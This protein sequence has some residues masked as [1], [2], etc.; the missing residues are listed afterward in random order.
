M[1]KKPERSNEKTCFIC[2]AGHS[3]STLLGLILGSH[4]SCFYAGEANKSR[5]INKPSDGK[6]SG[7]CKLCGPSCPIWSRVDPKG[8]IDLYE[9][10]SRLTNKPIIIDSTKNTRWITEKIDILKKNSTEIYL[11]YIQRD[12][13]AVINS[14]IRKYPDMDVIQ[15]IKD[16]KNQ[17]ELTN[18]LFNESNGKKMKIHYEELATNPAKLAK[19][20]CNFLEINYKSNLEE[21]YRFTHHPLGGNTGTQ[22]LITKVNQNL[23]YL[24]LNGHQ[25]QY[26]VDHPLEI[27]LDLRWK[28][29]LLPAHE[30]L[31]NSLAADLNKEF[32][33]N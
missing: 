10:L 12:G 5:F 18:K 32:Q 28:K 31:F 21:Y 22:S 16:W 14:R 26:Y 2:G 27:K 23:T 6:K 11:I 9:Q 25:R 30:E 33:W 13:R 7:I 1:T 8:S 29:E 19:E 20:T 15:L 24:Q 3:G 17:I 4:S